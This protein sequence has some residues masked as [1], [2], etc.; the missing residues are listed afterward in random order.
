VSDLAN[1]L[2]PSRHLAI[3][4]ELTKWFESIHTCALID[5]IP[6]LLA[7]PNHQKGEFVLIVSPPD[8]PTGEKL[9][10][11]TQRTLKLLLKELPLKQAVKLAVEISGESKK[12]IYSTALSLKPN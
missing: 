8:A 9:S 5:A 6:W 7:D 3:G 4:R 10:D 2:G 12:K 1:V 11:Q